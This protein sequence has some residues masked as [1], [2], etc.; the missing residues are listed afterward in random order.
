MADLNVWLGGAPHA[1]AIETHDGLA[2]DYATLEAEVDARARATEAAAGK[3][4]SRVLAL[5]ATNDLTLLLG[6]LVAWRLDATPWLVGTSSTSVPQVGPAAFFGDEGP[7]RAEGTRRLDAGLV[8]TTSGS[9]GTPKHVV[10]EHEGLSA[11]VDA[12]LEYLPVVDAPRTGVLVPL[13]YGYGL[14]GQALTTLRA[15]GTLLLL[16]G[17]SA[18]AAAQRDALVRFRAQ[19]VSSVPTQL[20]ALC[21]LG[22]L[23]LRYVASAGAPLDAATAEAMR[24]ACPDARR[25]NQYGLTEASPRVSALEDADDPK[26]FVRGGLGRALTG[27]SLRTDADEERSA[28][29][30]VRGPNVMRE[31]LD[32]PEGTR[33]VLDADG[34]LRTGDRVTRDALGRLFPAGRDDDVVKVA[35][36]RVSLL[37]VASAFEAAGECVVCAVP[38]PRS[39]LKL[40]AFVVGDLAHARTIAR[41]LPDAWRPSKVVSLASLPKTERGKV[42]RRRLQSWAQAGVPTGGRNEGSSE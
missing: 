1:T 5:T 2:W 16:R 32:D 23:E 22:P 37:R 25:F 38:S 6:V 11:N 35:G 17:V 34:W 20:R 24:R 3:L 33:A 31:Y 13:S 10:L 14:V 40:V 30:F 42:D 41:S 9:T 18:F 19:G 39:G 15:G 12:I 27:V 8:L 29:L 4:A 26:A 36:E 28:E 21:E 7:R